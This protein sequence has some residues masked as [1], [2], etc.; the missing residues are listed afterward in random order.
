[1]K[2]GCGR[3]SGAAKITPRFL[4]V[5]WEIIEL[6]RDRK[7]PGL[8]R[9]T[10]RNAC[11]SV[12]KYLAN[13]GAHIPAST[14]RGYHRQVESPLRANRSPDEME[15]FRD[16]QLAPFRARRERL[17]WDASLHERIGWPFIIGLN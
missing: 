7:T 1:M 11:R 3:P 10:V 4:I 8:E 2:S 15:K 13:Q 9:A 17:G 12:A 5:I 6:T 14:L 16:Y